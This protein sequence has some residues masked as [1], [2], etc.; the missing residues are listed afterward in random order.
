M[1]TPEVVKFPDGHLQHAVYGLGAYIADYPEQIWL[2]AIVQGWC[3][4]CVFDL[5]VFVTIK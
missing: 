2:A 1:T 4:K 5:F 3:A